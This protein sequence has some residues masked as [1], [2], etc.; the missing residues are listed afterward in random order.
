MLARVLCIDIF[1]FH[2]PVTCS[3]YI[4]WNS[5]NIRSTLKLFLKGLLGGHMHNEGVSPHQPGSR[6][7]F[8]LLAWAANLIWDVGVDDSVLLADA[9]S[10]QAWFHK[11]NN[12]C[13]WRSWTKSKP[14]LVCGVSW[15]SGHLIWKVISRVSECWGFPVS[16]PLCLWYERF[17]FLKSTLNLPRFSL[18]HWVLF[19][20]SCFDI[21]HV[22]WI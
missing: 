10:V 17:N 12:C 21:Q 13:A 2:C 6:K 19:V 5:D 7:Q 22:G 8:S 4:L 3:C 1:R 14:M 16:F 9:S 11:K 20:G 15:A 18:Q